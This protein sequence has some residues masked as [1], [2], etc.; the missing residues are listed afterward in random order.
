MAIYADLPKLG[1][2]KLPSGNVYALIDSDLRLMIAPSWAPNTQYKAGDYRRYDNLGLN[3][4]FSIA[5]PQPTAE[6]FVSGYYYTKSGSDYVVATSFVAGTT[7]YVQN[8]PVNASDDLYKCITDHTSSSTFDSSKW[9]KIQLASEMRSEIDRLEQAISGG[10]HYRGKTSTPLH[11]GD[12][13]NPI[14]INNESYTAAAGDLVIVDLASASSNY[15]TATAYNAHQYIKYNGKYY[16]VNAPIIIAE[17]TSFDAIASV[18]TPKA[19]AAN[20]AYSAGDYLFYNNNYYYVPSN[21]S[22]ATNTSWSAISSIVASVSDPTISR[23]S[24]LHGE[25]EFLFDGTR[26][27]AFGGDADSF[28]A[29][30]YK[31]NAS[32]TYIKPTGSGSVTDTDYSFGTKNLEM[33]TINVINGSVT[34]SKA[35]AETVKDVAK[36]GTA[37]VYGT[38][39]V[40][41][42]VV[43]GTANK[44]ASATTVGNANKASTATTVGN[45]NIGE[46]VSV[47]QAGNEVVY[48]TADVGEAVVY[49]KANVGEAVVYGKADVGTAVTVK[50]LGTVGNGNAATSGVDTLVEGDCLVFNLAPTASFVNS[51]TSSS[52]TFTPAVAAPTSQKINP[53]VAAPTSQKIT[54]AVAAPTSQK[55][56]PVS[57][58]VSLN[59]VSESTTQIYGAVDSNTQIYGAVDAPTGQKLTPAVAAPTSQ[60]ITPAVANGQIT[61]YTFEDVSVPTSATASVVVGISTTGTGA[62]VITS[63][64]G[65]SVTRTV[66]V[67]TTTDTVT[68]S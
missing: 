49:G 66:T 33:Q 42:A 2:V 50:E 65:T 8:T 44:A 61:P 13:T 16:H 25:P 12:T 53:A 58:T 17:N 54:P 32:G 29:L 21:I 67:G 36:A 68:V 63:V 51:V 62:Q 40:G 22:A 60:K 41:S 15:A 47:A 46:A 34:A 27:N 30:A 20:T 45:A 24:L 64:T 55:I 5:N 3:V 19:Y 56:T 23:L 43:Y 35:T 7:Y 31:D 4:T 38:A 10:I 26:W 52:V 14:I 48:G 28:G 37:V 59:Y 9:E 1:R 11:D 57:G 39:D 18:H 6:T